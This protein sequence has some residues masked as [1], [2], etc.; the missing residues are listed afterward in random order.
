MF[1]TVLATI[2]ALVL[3]WSYYQ[4]VSQQKKATVTPVDRLKNALL[5]YALHKV[6][7]DRI[8][9]PIVDYASMDGSKLPPM[10]GCDMSNACFTYIFDRD[11]FKNSLFY[12]P[13]MEKKLDAIEKYI[14]KHLGSDDQVQQFFDKFA[15]LH[16]HEQETPAT[17]E[18]H[19][20][21]ESSLDS[22][23]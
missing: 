15:K 12:T 17:I 18:S 21:D 3:G 16:S 13:H 5:S 14:Q 4:R 20:V 10:S 6:S 1:W 8:D 23:Q 2:C 9:S 22:L 11:E 19:A 7:T